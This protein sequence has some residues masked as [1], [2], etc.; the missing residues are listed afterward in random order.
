MRPGIPRLIALVLLLLAAPRAEA[1]SAAT[2]EGYYRAASE[3]FG[4]AVAEVQILAEWGLPADEVPVVLFMARRGGISADAV[5]ALR[6]SGRS[7]SDLGSRYGVHAGAL[8]VELPEGA[9]LGPLARAYGEYGA[10][11]SA[12]WPGI[13]L[14]D[15]EVVLLVNL[16]FLSEAVN[17]PPA[18]VL[19]V[20]ASAPSAADAYQS[21]VRGQ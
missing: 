18:E 1:Q 14:E 16:R 2:L 17:R 21:L 6:D 7:W 13:R 5:A 11:G 9:A 15:R 8:H 19:A 20:L 4:V 12:G 10:R 3:H